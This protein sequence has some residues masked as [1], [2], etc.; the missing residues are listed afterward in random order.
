VAFSGEVLDPDIPGKKFTET[1]MNNGIKE[2]E[3][4][5]FGRDR[6]GVCVDASLA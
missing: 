6:A 4:G 5:E 1:G 3:H 2:S